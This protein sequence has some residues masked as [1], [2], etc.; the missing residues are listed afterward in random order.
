MSHAE[1]RDDD[2]M[3]MGLG[4]ETL[5]RVDEY[6]GEV[7]IGGAC[8][9]VSRVLLVA[10]RVGDNE[11]AGGRRKIAVGD[12][13]GDALLALCLQ[14]VDEQGEIDFVLGRAELLRSPAPEQ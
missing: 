3:A 8:R 12:I 2:G 1:E 6:N 4:Q 11:R 14:S 5:A 10:G 13:D 7:R 9:H